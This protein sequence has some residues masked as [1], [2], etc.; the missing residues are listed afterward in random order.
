MA[1]AS[2]TIANIAHQLETDASKLDEY[3]SEQLLDDVL[4]LDEDLAVLKALLPVPVD[5][6]AAHGRL[7]AG[8]LEPFEDES[9]EEDEA[10]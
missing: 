8:E 5:W 4:V 7:I 1:E 9:D 6:D 3:A 2:G 10:G